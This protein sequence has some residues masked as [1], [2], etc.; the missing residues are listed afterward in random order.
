MLCQRGKGHVQKKDTSGSG[1]DERDGFYRCLRAH[2]VC[3]LMRGILYAGFQNTYLLF[4][5]AGLLPV[6]T[7]VQGVRESPV[8]PQAG[9][10]A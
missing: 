9:A 6:F 1:G 3:G 10:G 4:L 8:L 7:A 5:A 2:L